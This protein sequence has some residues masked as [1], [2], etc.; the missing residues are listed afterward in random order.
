VRAEELIRI[1]G[2]QT[3]LT[4]LLDK[5]SRSLP[6][7][8]RAIEERQSDERLLRGYQP[9]EV[10]LVHIVASNLSRK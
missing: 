10:T 3:F 8:V 9:T 4:P 2:F 7:P 6:E 5:E 1:I